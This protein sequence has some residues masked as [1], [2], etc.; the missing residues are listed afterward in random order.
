MPSPLPN[1]SPTA[2]H[3]SYFHQWLMGRMLHPW[4]SAD[5]WHHLL[6]GC[7]NAFC[8]AFMTPSHGATTCAWGR[9][10]MFASKCLQSGAA[11][12]ELLQQPAFKKQGEKILN[13]NHLFQQGS[14]K[15]KS[16]AIKANILRGRGNA[17]SQLCLWIIS[18]L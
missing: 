3:K 12:N 18:F 14:G 9:S 2:W 8:K 13:L 16:A 5:I 15:H 6:S 7:Q 17:S 4:D 1:C 11:V 10:H